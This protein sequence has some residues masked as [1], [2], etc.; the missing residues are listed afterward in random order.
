M[1]CI[2]ISL[3]PFALAGNF[4]LVTMDQGRSHTRSFQPF[5]HR[6]QE[7]NHT[8]SLYFNTFKPEIDFHMKNELIDL[9]KFLTNP[10]DDDAFGKLV[11][12]QEFS[13]FTQHSASSRPTQ[14]HLPRA[15]VFIEEITDE[16]WDLIF[17]DSLFSVCGYG[18]VQMSKRHHIMVHSSDVEGPHGTSKGFHKLVNHPF[19]S[20]GSYCTPKK[21]LLGNVKDFVS[22]PSSRGTIVVAFGTLVPWN[23]SPPDKLDAFVQVFNNLSEYRIVW[24]Y[25]GRPINVGR[26]VMISE[27]I[28]QNDLLLDEKTVLFISHG[29]LKRI[30]RETVDTLPSIT[31]SSILICH[32]VV[33]VLPWPTVLHHLKSRL[34]YSVKEAACSGMPALFMPMFAEQKRN[35][36][37]AK[38]KG[39]AD[40]LNKFLLTQP[41]LEEKIRKMLNTPDFKTKGELLKKRFLDQPLSSLDHAAFIVNRLLKYG[42]RMPSFFYTRSLELSYFTT[43]N[44]DIIVVIP[45]IMLTILL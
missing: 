7:D 45:L 32:A 6:L 15:H 23:L 27:W 41:Y 38:H 28:P 8:V 42:G 14:P 37:L 43:L 5:M 17:A 40:I 44:I 19:F 18:V 24:S 13:I 11:W 20:Y 30:A 1:L 34:S 25:K 12:N 33:V 16:N 2:I 35:S 4:L 9:S 3:L 39:F 21:A 10:F 22:D 31:E 36:W 29:G 26:H